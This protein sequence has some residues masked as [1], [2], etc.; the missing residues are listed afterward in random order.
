VHLRLA[1]RPE[2]VPARR[3]LHGRLPLDAV[4]D[5]LTEL[6]S[7]SGAQVLPSTAAR[8]DGVAEQICES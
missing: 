3:S 6:M 5:M 8:A 2:V 1:N 4:G 7:K